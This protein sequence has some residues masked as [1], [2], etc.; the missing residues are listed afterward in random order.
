LIWSIPNRRN[1]AN[2]SRTLTAS[3]VSRARVH[4]TA[5]HAIR[6]SANTVVIAVTTTSQATVSLNIRACPALCRAHGMWTTVGPCTGQ[7][8]RRVSA[9]G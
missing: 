2:G 8:A 6:S 3:A 9:A 4:P 7:A 5:R 1:P